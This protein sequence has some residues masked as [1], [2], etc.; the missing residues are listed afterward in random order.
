[1]VPLDEQLA[2]SSLALYALESRTDRNPGG[3]TYL[4][5]VF[6]SGSVK[7]IDTILSLPFRSDMVDRQTRRTWSNS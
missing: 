3:Y 5:L 6:V 2:V 4:T 7:S 1:M